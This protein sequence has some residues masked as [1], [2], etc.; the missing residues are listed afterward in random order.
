M[1]RI[2]AKLNFGAN[3]NFNNLIRWALLGSY[4]VTDA[5]IARDAAE[6]GS[7]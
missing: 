7:N 2:K 6:G 5:G 4:G 3:K 1:S